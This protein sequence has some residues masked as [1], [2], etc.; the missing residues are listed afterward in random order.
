MSLYE[1][2]FI[3]R[4]D[5]SAAQVEQIAEQ[6]QNIV[7]EGGG[8]IAKYENWGLRALAYRV[9]KNR[10]GHYI[11]FQVDSPATAIQEM[12]RLLRLNEDVLRYM[13]IRI[14]KIEDKPSV[15]MQSRG[16]GLRDERVR[17]GRPVTGNGFERS[18]D[19]QQP[20]MHEHNAPLSHEQDGQNKI[21]SLPE[22]AQ[23]VQT[24][25]VAP[26]PGDL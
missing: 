23:P 12:E 6:M 1:S 16:N 18:R 7:T 15:M 2:V 25:P 19:E 8:K 26:I 10:K 9:K 22:Q 20:P 13:T 4:Q 14:E 24:V 21:H 17:N 3:V 5:L 11:M